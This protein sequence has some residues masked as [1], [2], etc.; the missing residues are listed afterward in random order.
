LLI[1]LA[2]AAG[3]HEYWLI[4]RAAGTAAMI[5]SSLAICIAFYYKRVADNRERAIQLGAMHELLGLATIV[6]VAVHGFVLLG[7]DYLKPNVADILVP[8]VEPYKRGHIASGIVG[9]YLMTVFA[10]LYY[11]RNRIGP[12]R[13]KLIHRLTVLG[14]ALSIA[15]TFTTGPD[16][17]SL[18]YDIVL[19]PFLLAV[20]V[21][22]VLRLVG[23]RKPALQANPA[24]R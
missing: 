16:G 12:A 5:F 20:P 11:V 1:P 14:W 10:L 24:P 7:D 8:F 13:F 19:V 17:S 3:K 15:H 18:W 9:G 23:N 2:T 6:A 22:F 21:M 4:S